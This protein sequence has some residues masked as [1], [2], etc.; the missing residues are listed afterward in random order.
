M[1]KPGK[2][3]LDTYWLRDEIAR[4]L[5]EE[6]TRAAEAAHAECLRRFQ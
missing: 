6:E 2:I 4:I 1:L 3:S 5:T